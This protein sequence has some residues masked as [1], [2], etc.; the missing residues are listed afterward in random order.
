[1]SHPSLLG[2]IVPP[3]PSAGGDGLE[4]IDEIARAE[5]GIAFHRDVV[6]GN[7]PGVLLV[8]VIS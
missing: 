6:D 8:M 4:A 1:V 2:V 7:Q 5:H 3:S